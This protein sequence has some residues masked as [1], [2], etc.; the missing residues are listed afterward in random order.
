MVS[1]SIWDAETYGV[2]QNGTGVYVGFFTQLILLWTVRSGLEFG[3]WQS[4]QSGVGPKFKG[5]LQQ[6]WSRRHGSMLRRDG[7][8]GGKQGCTTQCA[9]S[10]CQLWMMVSSMSMVT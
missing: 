7:L 4:Q 1:R 9:P 8:V 6:Q 3:E 2:G 10:T 5:L